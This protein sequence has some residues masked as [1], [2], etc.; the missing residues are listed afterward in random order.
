[1]TRKPI[2]G[3]IAFMQCFGVILVVYAHSTYIE[4]IPPVL[5]CIGRWLCGFYMALFFFIS[6]Y[7][8]IYTNPD[9]RHV[10]VRKFLI[11]KTKRIIFPYILLNSIAFAPK[12]FFSEYAITKLS[13]SIT[14]YLTALIYVYKSPITYFWF[15]P[16]IFIIYI[17]SIILYKIIPPH[18]KYYAIFLGPVFL[19]MYLFNPIDTMG[20][21]ILGISNVFL[22]IIYFWC[23]SLFYTIEGKIRAIIDNNIAAFL[24]FLATV[25]ITY[26]F[27]APNKYEALVKAFS[28]IILSVSLGYLYVRYNCHAFDAINGYYYQIYLLS[29]FFITACRIVMYHKLGLGIYLTDITMFITGIYLPVIVTKVIN[30]RFRFLMVAVGT[31]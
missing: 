25:I 4:P 14:D 8:F 2:L 26:M 12:V 6:G 1:M 23:G 7:L 27:P 22:N 29:W 11:N 17:I 28:G 20:N 3:H 16:T 19:L 31:R 18:K 13:L 24:L 10:N 21:N 15:L 30:Y 9:A 5:Y